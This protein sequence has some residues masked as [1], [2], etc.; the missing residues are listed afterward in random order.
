MPHT[1]RVNEHSRQAERTR[2]AE[3]DSPTA[4]WRLWGPYLA[5]RQWGT[6]REDYSAGGDAWTSFPFDHA[7]SR[8]YRWGE[9][10]IAGICDVH[11]FLNL[12]VALWNGRDPILKE[13]YFGLTNNE[14]NHGEDV[15]EHWWVTDGT[16]THSWM[17]VV[18]RYPQREFP[19][20]ELR[21]MAG[22]AGRN[23]REP[24]L[25]DT[26]ALDG[27]RFFDVRVSYAK[28]GP[29]DVCV[30]LTATN[31]GSFADAQAVGGHA[32]ALRFASRNASCT[33]VEGC[34]RSAYVGWG[35]SRRS[36]VSASAEPRGRY[37]E[38]RRFV[39]SA[40][41]R[42]AF[43]RPRTIASLPIASAATLFRAFTRSVFGSS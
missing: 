26:G 36:P 32:S 17:Q 18:Y 11:G 15:K 30:E 20:A 35:R 21:E 37:F 38:G 33:G 28:A 8:A 34:A 7:R 13:R 25:S 9:D 12:G 27:N 41:R 19:Y 40:S 4:P 1:G 6:V 5:G 39:S 31:H 10:G 22:R 3:S 43:W 2:L 16:P 42:E 14:G 24:E 29:K 23:E